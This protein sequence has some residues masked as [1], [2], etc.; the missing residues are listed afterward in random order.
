MLHKFNDGIYIPCEINI[1][2]EQSYN[3]LKLE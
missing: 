3:V 1:E 2:Y